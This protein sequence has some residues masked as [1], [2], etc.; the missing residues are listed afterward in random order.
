[1]DVSQAGCSGAGGKSVFAN[2]M[3]SVQPHVSGY[4]LCIPIAQVNGGAGVCLLVS[5]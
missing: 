5:F 2:R 3:G 1:V 4:V